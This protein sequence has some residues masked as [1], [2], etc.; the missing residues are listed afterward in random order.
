[1]W[2]LNDDL[3]KPELFARIFC[4]DLDLPLNP[5][6]E[7]VANQ[8]RAQLEEY[9]GIVTMDL[10][11]CSTGYEEV[12]A[13]DVGAVDI[14]VPERRVIL[15]VSFRFVFCVCIFEGKKKRN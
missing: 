4:A 5:W 6:V 3:V 14:E 7:T 2:D 12:G 9:E 11:S 1:M 10:G 8:I 13:E 15:S